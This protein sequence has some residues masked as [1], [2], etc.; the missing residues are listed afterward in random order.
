MRAATASAAFTSATA[1]A[2]RVSSP[3][4]VEYGATM[5]PAPHGLGDGR[6]HRVELEP[7][8]G[9]PAG[10][11]RHRVVVAVVEMRA[12]GKHFHRLEAVAGDER[13]VLA[14]QPVIV[15]EVSGEP[16]ATLAHGE[17]ILPPAP[18]GGADH[19]R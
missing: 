15:K 8:L 3:E 17:P 16:E 6:V 19:L 12:R 5:S 11:V 10:E 13:Q 18:C 14:R 4:A 7:R 9:Q 2:R 1:A